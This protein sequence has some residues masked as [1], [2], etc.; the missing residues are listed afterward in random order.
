MAHRDSHHP[1]QASAAS[2]DSS[3][4]WWFSCTPS[5]EASVFPIWILELA[6]CFAESCVFGRYANSDMG[7][8]HGNTTSPK[9]AKFLF[10]VLLP[11][12]FIDTVQ[13]V[14]CDILLYKWGSSA[15]TSIL[16][17]HT[18]TESILSNGFFWSGGW[19]LICV[20]FGIPRS[21]GPWNT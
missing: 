11:S 12:K 9:E 6:T 3:S 20:F 1:Q 18:F 10:H 16:W 5:R 2:M 7:N 8:M 13:T 15:L 21:T 19:K 17:K 14:K 4:L